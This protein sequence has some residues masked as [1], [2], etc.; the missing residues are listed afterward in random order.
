MAGAGQRHV[1]LAQVLPQ[2]LVV[3]AGQHGLVGL[4]REVAAARFVVP[5]ERQVGGLLLAEGADEGQE[6]QR[7]LQPL[8]LVDGD[9]LHQVGIALQ[10]QA[11]GVCL[12]GRMGAGLAQVAQQGVLAVELGAGLL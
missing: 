1:E 7:V 11:V 8:G 5:G 2:A 10:A 6:D 12:L 4:Q 3:G 9:H